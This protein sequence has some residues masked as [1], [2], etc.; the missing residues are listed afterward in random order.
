MLN[1]QKGH[2][3][4]QNSGNKFSND[5]VDEELNHIVKGDGGII[6]INENEEALKA[7]MVGRL[8]I[9]DILRNYGESID[10][11]GKS[12]D[13]HHEQIPSVQKHFLADVRKYIIRF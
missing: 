10:K 9:A 8:E 13:N 11:K 12:N 2:F 4:S 5:Q 1:F 6:G 7:W 3:V